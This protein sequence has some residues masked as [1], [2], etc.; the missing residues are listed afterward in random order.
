MDALPYKNML[1]VAL[2]MWIASM[3]HTILPWLWVGIVQ[4]PYYVEKQYVC[5]CIVIV[6]AIILHYFNGVT[7]YVIW[8]L[9]THYRSYI[10]YKFISIYINYKNKVKVN[11]IKKCDDL[12]TGDIKLYKFNG[13]YMVTSESEDGII[14][15]NDL[16]EKFII[17]LDCHMSTLKYDT[18]IYHYINGHI[19][20]HGEFV[21]GIH[22]KLIEYMNLPK[23]NIVQI[24]DT[25][26]Y[27]VLSFEDHLDD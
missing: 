23:W 16:A 18:I 17:N 21:E 12:T 22:L 1:V 27:N 5:I 15:T 3:Y 13:K 9:L 2:M 19:D 4:F 20:V 8:V 14:L 26:Y 6:N 7:L 25:E 10:V 11:Y 24:E